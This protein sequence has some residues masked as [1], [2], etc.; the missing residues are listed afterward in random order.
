M[1][2]SDSVREPKVC[3][4]APTSNDRVAGIGV[5]LF[6]ALENSAIGLIQINNNLG[7]RFVLSRE[8]SSTDSSRF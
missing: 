4:F 5:E 2:A 8:F 7:S 3:H 6:S 1:S